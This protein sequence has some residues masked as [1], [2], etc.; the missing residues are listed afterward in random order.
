MKHLSEEELIALHY[1]EPMADGE[2]RQHLALCRDCSADYVELKQV[3]EGIQ[4][5]AVAQSS[6]EYGEQ[7]WQALL[8]SLIPYDRPVRQGWRFWMH[9]GTLGL[10]AACALA[11]AISFVG[12][13][14]WERHTAKTQQVAGN[15]SPLAAHR[16]VLVV[17]TDHLD[18]TERLLVA[19]DHANSGDTAQNSELQSQARELLA[20][21]RLYRASASEAGDPALA[22]TLDRLERVLAELA[23]E[24]NLR[25]ADLDRMRKEMNTDG[26][27]F[28]IRVLLSK[29]PDQ[30]TAARREKGDSI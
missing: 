10:A 8:P 3:L 5:I 30:E 20:S 25:A 17:V 2:A 16:V 7:V 15:S 6:P 11:L 14:L 18:R 23:N 28:E 12:G 19:L 26:I 21:N 27:L 9:W 29:T 1:G 4:P 22:G 24:P 13:R